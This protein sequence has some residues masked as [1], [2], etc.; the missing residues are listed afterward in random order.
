VL[1][2]LHLMSVSSAIQRPS[3]FLMIKSVIPA[4]KSTPNA[5]HATM[6]VPA[7]LASQTIL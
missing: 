7:K 4:H 2:V 3:T 1:N 5:Q 6:M